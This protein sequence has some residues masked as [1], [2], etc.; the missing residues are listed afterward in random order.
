ML[1]PAFL[2]GLTQDFFTSDYKPLSSDTV[3]INYSPKTIDVSPGG[4]YSNY[5]WE[6]FYHIPVMIAVHLSKNQ[7]FAEA[8]KWFHLVFDPTS[9][10]TLTPAPERYW[11]FLGFRPGT[12]VQ[13][14]E[15][16]LLLLST[17]DSDLT[18]SQIKAKQIVL[19]GYD[20]IQQ[21]PF[22]PHLVAA[23]RTV[24]YQYY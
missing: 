13:N 20:A 9:S 1:D 5:N 17:P 24:A 16:L 10:D 2:Q 4:P 8:Q 7:R 22:K 23:T 18:P 14:I 11:R 19:T 21:Y 15:E 3:Q 6:L 12:G